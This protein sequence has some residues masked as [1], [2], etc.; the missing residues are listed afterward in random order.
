M[1]DTLFIVQSWNVSIVE[2]AGLN[3]A[4]G[5]PEGGVEGLSV[6]GVR[7]DGYS[8]VF[9]SS[10]PAGES[11]LVLCLGRDIATSLFFSSSSELLSSVATA[12]SSL[13]GSV[14]YIYRKILRIIFTTKLYT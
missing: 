3:D 8:D 5:R 2:M 10:F 14:N 7:Y 9:S 11:E 1:N 6:L 13:R 4:D 12:K